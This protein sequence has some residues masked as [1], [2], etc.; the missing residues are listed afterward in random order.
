MAYESLKEDFRGV[1]LVT[2]T[3]FTED[4]ADVR[5]DAVA[6]NAR[7]AATAGIGLFIAC[8]GVSEYYSLSTEERVGVVEA[9]ADAVGGEASV[10]GGVGGS[11]KN[12]VDLID[13]YEDAGAD[14]VM[15]MFPQRPGLHRDGLVP[16][17]RQVIESTDLG[18]MLYKKDPRLDTAILADLGGYEN[19]VAVK[20]ALGDLDDF[21]GDINDV[22]ADL[23]WV[24]GSAEV[25][26]VG[27]GVEGAE[28]FTTGIG[29]FV[30]EL[31]VALM[32][33]IDRRDWERARDLRELA[34]PF[35]KIRGEVPGSTGVG[36]VK[37]GMEVAGYDGGPVRP[38]LKPMA[39]EY[40]ERV[41]AAYEAVAPDL[42][43]LAAD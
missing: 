4:G 26:A 10:V 24:D 43:A 3:P 12:A 21:V 14:A 11:T 29:N 42:D 5:Y 41:E 7:E 1:N 20:H 38:P 34:R 13:R 17:Y 22:D 28:G 16:H 39:P 36:V 27:F 31:A 30:P 6:A 15:V 8:G 35:Q 9:T 40:R 23:V 18:V 32:D 19:V 37:H 2:A 33:A 25:P